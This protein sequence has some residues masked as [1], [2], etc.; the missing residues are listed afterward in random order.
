LLAETRALAELAETLPYPDA[1][2][3]TRI[4]NLLRNIAFVN[5]RP[6]FR[7]SSIAR[8]EALLPIA[9]HRSWGDGLRWYHAASLAMTSDRHAEG[10]GIL[11]SIARSGP[12]H[13]RDV[14]EQELARYLVPHRLIRPRCR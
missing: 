8:I 5:G 9:E 11:R 13:T 7:W 3:G 1:C 4:D 6:D 12:E 10:V 14:A 2:L